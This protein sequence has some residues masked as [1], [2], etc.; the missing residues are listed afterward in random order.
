MAAP[1][2]DRM[3]SLKQSQPCT[4]CATLSSHN[5]LQACNRHGTAATASAALGRLL[6]GTVLLAAFREEQATTQVCAM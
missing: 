6:M 2:H 5:T 1:L 4:V 3:P